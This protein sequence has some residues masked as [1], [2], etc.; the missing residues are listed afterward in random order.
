MLPLTKRQRE[1]L[2]DDLVND[3]I[4]GGTHSFPADARIPIVD[5]DGR[6]VDDIAPP[7]QRSRAPQHHLFS[8]RLEM[9][10][11]ASRMHAHCW[12]STRKIGRVAQQDR[13]R[14]R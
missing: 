13:T 5:P 6:S 12:T 9:L 1:I 7:K 11:R 14:V 8:M 10:S 4:L 3:A 2:D